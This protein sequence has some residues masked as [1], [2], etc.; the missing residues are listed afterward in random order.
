MTPAPWVARALP[1][2]AL[3]LAVED[4]PKNTGGISYVMPAVGIGDG[5][6]FGAPGVGNLEMATSPPAK[7]CVGQK[8]GTATYRMAGSGDLPYDV[9][10]DIY[11]VVS[12]VQGAPFSGQS[13][14]RRYPR[15]SPLQR[16][17]GP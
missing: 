3:A 9:T 10:T 5:S 1:E 17:I 15:Y 14:H 13:R 6:R 2:G 8:V 11:D 16:F 7:V 4:T 12:F